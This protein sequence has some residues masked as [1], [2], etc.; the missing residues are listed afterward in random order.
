M[1]TTTV[2]TGTLAARFSPHLHGDRSVGNA[3]HHS[4][5]VSRS[6][7]G[8]CPPTPVAMAPFRSPFAKKPEPEGGKGPSGVETVALRIKKGQEKAKKEGFQSVL[9][10]VRDSV[11]E[12]NF[13]NGGSWP[14]AAAARRKGLCPLCSSDSPMKLAEQA[15]EKGLKVD[16][17]IIDPVAQAKLGKHPLGWC[18]ACAESNKLIDTSSGF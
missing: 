6:S 18:V 4:C 5:C 8:R 12:R 7:R 16:A 10:D 15:E 14:E 1:A 9:S 11:N 2:N 3:H 17:F 13:G